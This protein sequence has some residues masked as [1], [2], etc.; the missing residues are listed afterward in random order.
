[1]SAS[2]GRVAGAGR[3]RRRVR[4]LFTCAGRRVALISAFVR[5]GRSLGLDVVVETADAEPQT[6]AGCLADRAHHV[7]AVRSPT[8]IPTLLDIA[9][10]RKIDLVFPLL[11]LELP[12]LARARPIFAQAG[13]QVVISS[14]RVIRRCRDKLA[15]FAFFT[16]E[17]IEMPATWTPDE[18]MPR[19]RHRFPYFL[20]PRR[21]SAGEGNYLI[22]NLD[23]L[24]ALVPR[25]PDPIIQEFIPGPEFTL[26]VYTGFDGRPRCAVPRRRLEVRGGEVT[27]ARTVK[28]DRIIRAGFQ[29]AETLAECRGVITVQLIL[30]PG[31]DLRVIE[32]NPRF[33]GGAPLAV[34]AGANL[35][36][37]LLAEW[38]GRQ[39]RIRP[40]HFRDGVTMLR[41]HESFVRE[42]ASTRRVR[43]GRRGG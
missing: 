40:D 43:A 38:M 12:K 25:V 6:A 39:P 15:L 1:M 37:W 33:G 22:R 5:A 18:V 26:D 29:V 9:R 21:G 2:P 4:L 31:G 20:K 13:T 14:P 32:V 24:Q 7:P 11:D 35:P 19:R 41:Y 10:K 34:Y 3:G 17:G 36:R 23:D 8:Y 28:D 30:T 27:K 42:G 16:R